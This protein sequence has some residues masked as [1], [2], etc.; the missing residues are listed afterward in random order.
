MYVYVCMYVYVIHDLLVGMYVYVY[1]CMHACIFFT[2]QANLGLMP[3]LLL[4]IMYV[5]VCMY[6]CIFYTRPE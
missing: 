2:C 3:A 1:V 4:S 6:V 5:F